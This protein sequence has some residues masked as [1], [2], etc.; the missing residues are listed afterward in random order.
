[1]GL[2]CTKL[3]QLAKQNQLGLGIIVRQHGV[4]PRKKL[5]PAMASFLASLFRASTCFLEIHGD[6]Q[7]WGAQKVAGTSLWLLFASFRIFAKHRRLG[8]TY[9]SVIHLEARRGRSSKFQPPGSEPE[10]QMLPCPLGDL[11]S[12]EE[13]LDFKKKKKKKN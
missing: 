9:Q 5:R 11:G 4:F 12:P 1:M 3:T 7:T 10:P 2:C 6:L 13:A 8:E